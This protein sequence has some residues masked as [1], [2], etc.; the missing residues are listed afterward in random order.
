MKDIN[1]G[2]FE[3]FSCVDYHFSEGALAS[4]FG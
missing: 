4:L 1:F 3:H 2:H